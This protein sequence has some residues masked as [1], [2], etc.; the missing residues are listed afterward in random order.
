MPGGQ[1]G[2]V[3]LTGAG[4]GVVVFWARGNWGCGRTGINF[5]MVSPRP[6]WHVSAEPVIERWGDGL[7]EFSFGHTMGGY[8]CLRSRAMVT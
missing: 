4:A 2:R 8:G 7:L 3:G 5:C 6:G 1:D